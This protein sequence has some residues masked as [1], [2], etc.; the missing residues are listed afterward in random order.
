MVSLHRRLGRVLRGA[1]FWGF[2]AV[3]RSDIMR[4]DDPNVRQGRLSLNIRKNFF[5]EWVIKHWSDVQE[6][7]GVTVP[8]V[9]KE[10]LGEAPRAVV[11][12]VRSQ[13]DSMI[14]QVFFSLFDSLILRTAPPVSVPR[15]S[16]GMLRPLHDSA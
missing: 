5:T 1:L 15:K 8:E 4:G 12:G 16:R 3:P 6:S 13:F 11:V 7:G 2:N 14:P 9:F 10:R